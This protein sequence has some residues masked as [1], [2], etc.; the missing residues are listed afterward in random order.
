MHLMEFSL[1]VMKYFFV[2]FFFKYLRI[3]DSSPNEINVFIFMF[4]YDSS[5]SIEKKKK[6]FMDTKNRTPSIHRSIQMLSLI[7]FKENV[8]FLIVFF[9][10]FLFIKSIHLIYFTSKIFIFNLVVVIQKQKERIE[11]KF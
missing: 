7:K 8:M 1:E 10:P 9:L 2:L 5:C 11:S 3:N 6:I 4:D